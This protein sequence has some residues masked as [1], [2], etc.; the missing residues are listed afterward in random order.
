VEYEK[1]QY[2]PLH[3]ILLAVGVTLLIGVPGSPG[4]S[5]AR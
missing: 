1:T 5:P 2:A 3:Y 4:V